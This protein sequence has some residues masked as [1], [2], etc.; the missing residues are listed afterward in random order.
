MVLVFFMFLLELK[1]ENN[2]KN[3]ILVPMVERMSRYLADLDPTQAFFNVFCTQREIFANILLG[4]VNSWSA[5]PHLHNPI[6]E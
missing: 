5:L 6:K 3:N 2:L 1:S 4:I